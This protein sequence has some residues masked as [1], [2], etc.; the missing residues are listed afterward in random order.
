MHVEEITVSKIGSVAV[1]NLNR[2][3]AK[4]AMSI[5]A[6]KRLF[7]IWEEIDSDTSTSAI[8]LTSSDCGCF[9]A[10][11]DLKDSKR[12]QEESGKDILEVLQ[13]PFY[14]R[15][16]KVK[17]PLIAAMTGDFFGAGILLAMN[18]D[19][20]IG[21]A[22]TSG[23]I[24]E[25]KYGRGSPW[26]TPLLYMLP[27]G[28]NLEMIMTAAPVSVDRLFQ[29]GFVNHIEPDP[30]SVR[31]RAMD[32]ANTIAAN[33]PLSVLIGKQGIMDAMNL[34]D[35]EARSHSKTLHRAVYSSNDAKEGPLAFTQRR[36][37]QWTGT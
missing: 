35:N 32:L 11:M 25:A 1:V 28:I 27:L 23:G 20:R 13:D 36:K 26:A 10:G 4:N 30:E 2:P 29:L 12:V 21:M 37:P 33:A 8:I 18:S 24:S 16:R 14:E 22:G 15:M 3:H 34:I 17:K 31:A 5:S 6:N 9:C 7:E 19:I